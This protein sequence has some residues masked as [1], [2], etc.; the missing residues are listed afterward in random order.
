MIVLPIPASDE[1]SLSHGEPAS[2][3]RAGQVADRS[4][5]GIGLPQIADRDR[6]SLRAGARPAAAVAAGRARCGHRRLVRASRR[7]GLA[8]I[9]ARCHG[10]RARRSGAGS[11]HALGQGA[12]HLRLCRRD[13]LRPDL[14]TGGAGGARPVLAH[15]QMADFVGQGRKRAAGPGAA[16]DTAGGPSVGRRA[17]AACADQRSGGRLGRR[18]CAGRDGA[19]ARLADAAGADGG[20]G[21]L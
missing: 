11:G 12:R 21:R 14:G 16:D 20:A 3:R 9:S 19:A 10:L 4:R 5:R 7:A 1:P 2:G 6:T 8:R 17:A 18:S 15:P 13:R